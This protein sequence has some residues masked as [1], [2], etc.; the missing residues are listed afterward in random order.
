MGIAY[1][2]VNRYPLGKDVQVFYNP[3][4]PQQSLLEPGNFNPG[5]V[6]IL[7]SLLLL[8]LL[9]FLNFKLLHERKSKT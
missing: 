7:N 8:G 4:N 1:R 3:S 9:F 6:V 2:M 5:M